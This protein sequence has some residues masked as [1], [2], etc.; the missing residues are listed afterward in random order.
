MWML[1][2]LMYRERVLLACAAQ[3]PKLLPKTNLSKKQAAQKMET[4]LSSVFE[5]AIAQDNERRKCLLEQSKQV[6]P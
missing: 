6:K 4:M 2:E 3:E 5:D 1:K